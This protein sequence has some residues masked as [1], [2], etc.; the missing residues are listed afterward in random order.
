MEPARGAAPAA[1]CERKAREAVAKGL[2][3]EV[4][5]MGAR[6]K[7]RLR[8]GCSSR[9]ARKKRYVP[10]SRCG[11]CPLLALFHRFL[12]LGLHQNMSC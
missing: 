8:A 10:A 4:G 3:I 11:P 2:V 1:V 9:Y 6:L 7:R 12:P 5:G